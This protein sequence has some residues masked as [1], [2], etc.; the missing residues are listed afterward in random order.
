M[1]KKNPHFAGFFIPATQQATFFLLPL[2]SIKPATYE[3]SLYYNRIST[4]P[5][6][7][8]R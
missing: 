3:I 8:R 5:L 7:Y 1:I 4:C 2:S 6:S